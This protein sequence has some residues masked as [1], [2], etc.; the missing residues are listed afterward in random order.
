MI[1]LKKTGF[2]LA[3]NDAFKILDFTPRPDNFCIMDK[4]EFLLK[5]LEI[6]FENESVVVFGKLSKWIIDKPIYYDGGM[7]INVFKKVIMHE[8][9]IGFGVIFRKTDILIHVK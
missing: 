9:V 5:D 1:Y 2:N 8:R 7:N 6:S 3:K 4:D